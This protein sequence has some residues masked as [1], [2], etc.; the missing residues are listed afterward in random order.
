MKPLALIVESDGGTRR[1][2]DVL[3]SRLGMDVDVVATTGDALLLLEHVDY[4][5]IFSDFIPGDRNATDFLDRLAVTHRDTLGRTVIL[6]SSSPA[7][8]DELRSERPQL[9]T[10]RK[11]FELSEITE[12]VAAA[13]AHPTR[14]RGT[15]AEEFTRRSVRAGAKA[16]LV[17]HSDGALLDAT[18]TFGYTPAQLQPFLPLSIDAPYPL[19]AAARHR[20]PVWVASVL[21]ASNDY[22][23]LVSTWQQ[24]QSR[25]L[26]AVPVMRNGDLLGVAGWAFREP[27]LFSELE[28]Q[29]FLAIAQLIGDELSSDAVESAM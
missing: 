27:R 19:C 13:S 15:T 8:L 29:T 23:T 26:A 28:R 25:A 9:R 5:L 21:L 22:P 4:D 11:P 16:G 3:L 17:L 14:R 7:H 12:A 24:N 10:I 1:L 2:L 20:R 18:L 6:S